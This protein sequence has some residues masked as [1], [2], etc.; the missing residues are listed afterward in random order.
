[1]ALMV[2]DDSLLRFALL[3]KTFPFLIHNNF[4]PGYVLPSNV[5]FTSDGAE[6]EPLIFFTC[7]ARSAMELNHFL[8][9]VFLRKLEMVEA[10]QKLP[11]S[12]SVGE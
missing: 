2:L 1:M 3:T 10:K 6:F 9:S 11:F 4:H 5:V 7:V 12:I 8:P